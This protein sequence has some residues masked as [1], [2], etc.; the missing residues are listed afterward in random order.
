MSHKHKYVVNHQRPCECGSG[1]KAHRCCDPSGNK[2]IRSEQVV[3]RNKPCPCGSGKK[4]KRCCRDR[5]MAIASL[6][7]QL[8]LQLGINALLG[9][10]TQPSEQT[11][12][13]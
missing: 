10:E 4:A 2:P 5:I 13:A 6:P 11:E 1:K 7:Q 8:R 9:P 12:S 3:G